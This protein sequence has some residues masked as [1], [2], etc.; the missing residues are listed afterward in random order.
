MGIFFFR[1]LFSTGPFFRQFFS[2][3]LCIHDGPYRQIFLLLFLSY[4]YSSRI[5]HL[6]A[7]TI[8]TLSFQR[9]FRFFQSSVGGHPLKVLTVAIAFVRG[10]KESAWREFSREILYKN[11]AIIAIQHSKMYFVN[12]HSRPSGKFPYTY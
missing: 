12:T 5:H 9:L 2:A 8:T 10:H 1:G 4:Y 6:P 7:F 3:Y 11:I